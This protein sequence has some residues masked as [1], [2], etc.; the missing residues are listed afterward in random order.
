[1]QLG[2]AAVRHA[3]LDR[4]DRRL[5]WVDV[6]PV[7]VPLGDGQAQVSG[8]RPERS[9]HSETPQKAGTADVHR[10]EMEGPRDLVQ[11]QVVD[12]HDLASI[13]IH[14]LLVHQVRAQEDLVRALAEFADVDRR[15]PEPR[16]R[17]V[18]R[19]HR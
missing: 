17:L 16:A 5:D 3:Q 19:V 12:P 18:H 1:M 2:Q 14:D 10:N 9:L 6:L 4:G 8:E 7:D 13:D 11:S 15:R